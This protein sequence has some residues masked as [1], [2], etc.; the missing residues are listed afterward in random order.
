MTSR[1][2]RPC[3][4]AACRRWG[5]WPGDPA[6]GCCWRQRRRWRWC[7]GCGGSPVGWG[8]GGDCVWP[9]ACQG[10]VVLPG[11][12]TATAGQEDPGEDTH[13]CICVCMY[14]DADC[15]LHPSPGLGECLGGGEPGYTHVPRRRVMAVAA[16]HVPMYSVARISWFYSLSSMCI[17]KVW[18]IM[19]CH[20]MPC[21]PLPLGGGG[22]GGAQA[23]PAGAAAAGGARHKSRVGGGP[24][25]G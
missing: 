25:A 5:G 19:P 12:L 4:S 2:G 3:S 14:I 16:M 10:P 9:R 1:C 21:C 24:G 8:A 23:H 7:G 15:R 17:N 11:W 13:I 20:A 18:C 22:A 6:G